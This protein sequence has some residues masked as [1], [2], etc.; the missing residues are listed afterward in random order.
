MTTIHEPRSETTLSASTFPELFES[1]VARTPN[2][3]ALLYQG[4]STTYADLNRRVNRLAKMLIS[5]KLGT[6]QLVAL[7]IP[8]SPALI[9]AALAV[10]KA[11]AAYL[12]IDPKHPADHISY[13]L[14]D[15]RPV[16]TLT[17][18]DTMFAIPAGRTPRL[19]LD[20]Q[21]VLNAL[22]QQPDTDPT[23]EARIRPL[24]PSNLAYVIYTS[25]STGR[26]KGVMIEHRGVENLV[27]SQIERFGVD[28]HSRVLQ[29]APFSFDAAF[30]ELGMALLSGATLVLA[31]DE[32]LLPGAPLTDLADE[33]AITHLTVPPTVLGSL[34]TGSLPPATTLIVAGEDCPASLVDQWAPGRK[35]F[36]AYGPT[37]AT[38]CATM[39]EPLTGGMKPPI[40]RPIRDTRVYVLDDQLQTVSPGAIGELC[41]AGPGVARGYLNHDELT[42]ERFVPDPDGP[43]GT[44]M[45]RTGDLVCQ[46]VDGALEY[47]GRADEQVKIR[48]FRIELGEIRAV[49]AEHAG[50]SASAVVARTH[51]SGSKCL[52]AYV[53]PA[54][55][56]NDAPAPDE[57]ALRQHLQERLPA[58]MVPAAFVLLNR[59][60]TTRHGKL[61]HTALPEPEFGSH[62]PSTPFLSPREELLCGLFAEVL[63]LP[64]V[65]EKDNFFDCGGNSLLAV[66]LTIRIRAELGEELSIRTLLDAPTPHELIA[67]LD[68]E[69]DSR[70]L[71]VVLPLRTGGHKTP[72]FC[73]H[74]GIGIGWSYV[75]LLRHLPPDLPIYGIQARGLSGTEPIHRCIADM[76]ND[77]LQQI[78]AIQPEG[79]YRLLG[80]SFGGLLAHDI[81]ARLQHEGDDVELLTI[82]DAY[83]ASMN[84]PKE[85]SALDPETLVALLEIVGQDTSRVDRETLQL[86]DVINALRTADGGLSDLTPESMEALIEIFTVNLRL[87]NEFT[88]GKFRGD[89]ILFSA[90]QHQGN[91]WPSPDTWKPYVD[92]RIEHHPLN[93]TH[94]R[95]LEEDAVM[96]IAPILAARLSRTE[97]S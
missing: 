5:R 73:I 31:P 3:T 85:P 25:G 88:P 61:D 93:S 36:N 64:A 60:P 37:E 9:T 16:L 96:H 59:L 81:A 26:P 54:Q 22:A 63:G 87:Q 43:P 55:E 14:G 39:S 76:A 56:T 42:A 68:G 58:H 1:Q 19:V 8:R 32:R 69:T 13:V 50:V 72:L 65:S 48:G 86:P 84:L 51:P 41:V 6:E 70:A 95:M 7:A 80:W 75:R 94:S 62:T 24:S 21:G 44:R 53:V 46:R 97:V 35:M 40:G 38:V 47:V 49:L 78:R 77:Y 34:P 4:E 27:A 18:R 17:T 92:G 2:A 10:L 57:T 11:G 15:A 90:C 83:P 91:G 67:R 74:P 20:G 45:Y 33:C 89:L 82:L 66:K 12:P 23:D 71:D 30:S 28:H 79:S 52:I 29:F